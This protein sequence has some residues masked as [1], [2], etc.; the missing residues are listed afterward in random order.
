MN[1]YSILSMRPLEIRDNHARHP[2]PALTGARG[3]SDF[4]ILQVTFE[5]GIQ[6]LQIHVNRFRF[7]PFFDMTQYKL[8]PRKWT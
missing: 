5:G 7:F 1:R 8:Y 2:A 4:C 3:F 6:F